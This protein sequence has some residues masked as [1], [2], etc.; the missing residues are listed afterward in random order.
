VTTF[1]AIDEIGERNQKTLR[2]LGSAGWRALW[3]RNA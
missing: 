3:K 1:S 2:D